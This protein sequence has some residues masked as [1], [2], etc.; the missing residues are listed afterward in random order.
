[1]VVQYRRGS[2]AFVIA[3]EVAVVAGVAGVVDAEAR[4]GSDC[5]DSCGS[6]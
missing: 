5:D 1:M 6:C 2:K 4:Q 3:A